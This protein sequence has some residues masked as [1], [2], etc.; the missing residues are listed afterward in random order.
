MAHSIFAAMRL[1]LLLLLLA[2]VAHGS[3]FDFSKIK[4]L[5][6][7]GKLGEKIKNM[8]LPK[9][10]EVYEHFEYRAKDHSSRW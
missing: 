6:A 7:G 2:V 8:T 1:I 3:F 9:L 10:K 4:D 5:L